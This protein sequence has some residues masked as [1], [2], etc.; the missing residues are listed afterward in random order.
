[1]DIRR[2]AAAAL[3]TSLAA[4]PSRADDADAAR[5][6]ECVAI[7]DEWAAAPDDAARLAVE[8]RA[9][10]LPPLPA[11][12]VQPVAAR[13][14]EIAAKTGPKLKKSGS[15]YFYDEKEKRG[16]YMVAPSGKK[17]GGLLIAMH[18][19]GESVG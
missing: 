12:A 14:F 11:G 16:L 7:C 6:A 1:M 13:L 4:A 10:K 18:G 15:G 8:A 17:H 3:L 19:G 2:L 9:A 5:V